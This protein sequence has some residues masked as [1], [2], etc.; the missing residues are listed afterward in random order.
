MTT[1]N[2]NRLILVTLACVIGLV[3][4]LATPAAAQGG[5]T[6]TSS[7]ILYHDG[8]VMDGL[9]NVYFIWYGCWELSACGPEHDRATMNLVTDLITGIGGSPYIAIN[10]LYPEA[11]GNAPSGG[12]VFGGSTIDRYSH[13]A[14]LMDADVQDVVR[15]ATS[16]G[17][18][19]FDTQGVYIVLTSADA[20][21]DGFCSSFA[22]YH[23]MFVDTGMNMQYAAVGNPWRC[24]TSAAPQF[25]LPNG[26]RLPTPNDNFAADAMV[27]SVA[28][29]LDGTLTNPWG[30]AWFDRYGL[31]NSDKCQG[32]FGQTY[33]TANGA[34][35]NMMLGI[36]DYLIQQNWINDRRGY[37]GLFIR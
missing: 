26:S 31:E 34:Q 14:T 35:A 5:R 18:L 20:Y 12:I 22:Q 10:T 1:R 19:P 2:R 3:A 11:Y 32:T 36:R 23:S 9:M 24:P 16:S 29:V 15:N 4:L 6:K 27:S 30:M 8:P 28:H 25:M 21:F 17:S 37:C 33:T 7:K 13:T